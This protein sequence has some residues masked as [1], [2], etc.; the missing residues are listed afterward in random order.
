ML[1][2]LQVDCAG[3]E[4]PREYES[5]VPHTTRTAGAITLFKG[6]GAVLGTLRVFSGHVWTNWGGAQQMSCAGR[7]GKQD[8]HLSVKPLP[9]H[10]RLLPI[11]EEAVSKI[12]IMK[13][14]P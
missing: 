2:P 1:S 4:V 10:M 13:V 8:V 12:A 11:I 6:G 3:A 14:R 5:L 7:G 9:K